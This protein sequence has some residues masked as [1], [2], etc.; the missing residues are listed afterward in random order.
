M[1][2]VCKSVCNTVRVCECMCGCLYVCGAG[3]GGGCTSSVQKSGSVFL[4]VCVRVCAVLT[5]SVCVGVGVVGVGVGVEELCECAHMHFF[6]CLSSVFIPAWFENRMYA[7]VH[8]RL[9][10]YLSPQVYTLGI[11]RP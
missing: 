1:D 4:Y 8:S 7:A 9:S 3:G 5:V 2:V 10:R 11:G 6:T